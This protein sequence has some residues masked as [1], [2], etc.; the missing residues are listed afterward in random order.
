MLSPACKDHLLRGLAG[1]YL[2]LGV[3]R[4]AAVVT[5]ERYLTLAVPHPAFHAGHLGPLSAG[6]GAGLLGGV[7]VPAVMLGP[8][9]D[10]SAFVLSALPRG[11]QGSAEY[12]TPPP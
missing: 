9:A 3:V 12:G 6:S 5:M 10:A 1:T 8:A 11:E 2:A 7:V 4:C